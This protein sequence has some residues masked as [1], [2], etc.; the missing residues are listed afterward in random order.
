MKDP[1]PRPLILDEFNDNG[2]LKSKEAYNT[3][4]LGLN[5]LMNSE[6]NTAIKIKSSE[7]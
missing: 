3:E 1:F 2:L 5:Q 4:K 7:H 6:S